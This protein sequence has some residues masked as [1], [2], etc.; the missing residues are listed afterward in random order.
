MKSKFIVYDVKTTAKMMLS[1]TK[2]IKRIN[3]RALK[4]GLIGNLDEDEPYKLY[5]TRTTKKK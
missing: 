4:N 2:K 1:L 3:K 5:V